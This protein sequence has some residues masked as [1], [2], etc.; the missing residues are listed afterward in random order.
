MA[1]A[2]LYLIIRALPPYRTETPRALASAFAVAAVAASLVTAPYLFHTREVTGSWTPSGKF[3]PT[4]LSGDLYQ[5]LVRDDRHMFAYLRTWWAL[6]PGHEH[7]V[8]PYWGADPAQP[9]A[10]RLEE[11]ERALHGA[12]PAEASLGSRLVTRAPAYL[13][14]LW[15]LAGLLF[16]PLA[17][18]G[19]FAKGGRLADRWPPFLVAPLVASILTTAMVFALPRF[20]LY[21]VPA[22]S[23]WSARGIVWL[24]DAARARGLMLGERAAA[25]ALVATG[26]VLGARGTLGD[27]AGALRQFATE[28][29]LASERLTEGLGEGKSLMTWHPRLAYWGRFDWR[30]LPVAPLDATIHYMLQRRIRYLFLADGMYTPLSLTAPYVLVEV[31]REMRPG[32]MTGDGYHEHPPTTLESVPAVAGFPSGTV[33]LRAEDA[34]ADEP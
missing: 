21:L 32:F 13:S 18:L 24:V 33:R 19:L 9:A 22:F 28:N 25:L 2:G 4:R 8:N 26:I 23:F 10:D 27:E 7:L 29:R 1:V 31:P 16:A 34:G 3:E 20:F 5:D 14:A 6:D 15:S 30:A 17:L 12:W 11:F